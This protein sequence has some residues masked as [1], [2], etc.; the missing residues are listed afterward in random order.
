MK[1]SS[2][3]FL[4][5]LAGLSARPGMATQ[6]QNCNATHS[7]DPAQIAIAGER[8]AWIKRVGTATQR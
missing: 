5:I 6:Q 1:G 3:W 8:V 7:I 4:A 2:C